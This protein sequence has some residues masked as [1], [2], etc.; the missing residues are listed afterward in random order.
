MNKKESYQVD[1]RKFGTFPGV[2]KR[3]LVK[4][5]EGCFEKE[6]ENICWNWVGNIHS[7]G[8]G[9]IRWDGVTYNAHRM[10][11]L[12]FNGLIPQG[13]VVRHTCN[14][15]KCINPKHLIT[16]TYADNTIDAIKI[17]MHRSQKLT[18]ANVKVI[19]RLLRGKYKR[20]LYSK[21][22]RLFQVD[23]SSIRAI[24]KGYSY[25]W[26]PFEERIVV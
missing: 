2:K 8:Y 16:G 1:I 11:Y 10:A 9:Q 22:A 25:S 17:G 7:S 6:N 21:I 15:R 12:I 18:E 5:P 14:N 26:I 23:H 19:K 4:M 24:H 3:F 13:Q 20:G